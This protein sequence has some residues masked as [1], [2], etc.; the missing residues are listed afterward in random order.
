M[1]KGLINGRYV[2]WLLVALI[3]V[4]LNACGGRGYIPIQDLTVNSAKGAGAIVLH[5]QASPPTAPTAYIVKGGDTLFAIAWRYGWD[6]KKL[7][8]LNNIAPPYT[9]YVG[10]NIAFNTAVVT[11]KPAPSIASAKQKTVT[12]TPPSS[13]SSAQPVNKPLP[14]YK[15][16]D[17][18][19]WQWP[20]QGA[21]LE[22]FN[23]QSETSKGIDI[24]APSGSRVRAAAAGQ[25]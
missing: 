20:I 19:R 10:Q 2:A 12:T 22:K 23:S 17:S 16:A 6:Y 14:L 11:A 5:N 1:V 15:G 18:L 8:K 4:L 21:L 9:I 3:A 7:A 24:A 25:V 13:S